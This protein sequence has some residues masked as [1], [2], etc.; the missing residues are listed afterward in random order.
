MKEFVIK[1]NEANQRFDKYLKKILP[2]AGSGFIYKMLRKKN[3]T[4]DGKKATGTE[5]LKEN[6]VVKLFFSDE[7]FDKFAQDTNVVNGEYEQLKSLK[8]NGLKVIYEDDDILVADKPFNMLSQK[9]KPSDI[10]ANEYLIGYLI[11]RGSLSVEDYRTFK[12]SVCNRLDRNT[13]G[14]ILM[15]KSLKG[16]QELS[17]MLKERTIQ[18]YYLAVVKG[19]ISTKQDIKAYLTKDERT[20]KV[21]ISEK[22][23]TKESMFIETAYR[24][25][26]INNGLTLLEVHLITGRSHQIRAHLASIGHPVLGD[27]KY[28]KND[29][30]FRAQLLHAYKV[31]FPDGRVIETDRPKVFSVIDE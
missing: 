12:P 17:Q 9:A 16:S 2:N 10:S 13:T 24:P 4:L 3:I 20:N 5:M 8:M 27:S 22:P 7:T 30:R 21:T 11:R 26:K 6:S 31:V 18:K 14:I 1:S 25:L 29:S 28:G 23:V 15:G 19:E